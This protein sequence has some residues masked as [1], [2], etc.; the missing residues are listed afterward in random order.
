MTEFEFEKVARGA[1][2]PVTNTKDNFPWID[3]SA[4]SYLKQ[5]GTLSTGS[6]TGSET[7]ITSGRQR[8]N[9]RY[10]DNLLG[11]GDGDGGNNSRGPLRAGIFAA[12][13]S[14]R[15]DYAG[16]GYYGNMELSGNVSE[17]VVTVGNSTGR[18]FTGTHGDGTL[19][20]TTSYE[21]NATN[22]DWPG[23]A[24]T[25]SR[26]V[27]GGTGSGFR[28]GDWS[29]GTAYGR[30]SDRK[31]AGTTSPTRGIGNGIRCVRTAP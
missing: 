18:L 31:D 13:S 22:T 20:A 4:N 16:A 25:A 12:S 11:G 1:Y 8:A 26:G 7:V 27:E 14:G 9:I 17:H 19:T 21:G 2:V 24:T 10:G 15:P 28:G 5:A 3:K 6:E 29:I 30:V 23:I